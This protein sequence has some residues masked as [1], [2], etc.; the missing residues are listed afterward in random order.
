MGSKRI[1]LARLEAMVESLKRELAL[2][3]AILKGFRRS[4]KS[5]TNAA[6]LTLT[7]ADSGACVVMSGTAHKVTLP[8]PTAG[9]EYTIT[10]G[11]TAQYSIWT[12]GTNVMQ[13][14]MIHSSGTNTVAIV[15]V[16]A[17]GKIVSNSASVVGDTYHLRSDG[18]SWFVEACVDAVP[19]TG[20]F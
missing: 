17:Q 14:H 6:A 19:T 10:A 2:G 18:T 1:G 7:A 3:G 11:G 12:A 15:S 20:T 9:V 5:S 8:A 16:V 4:V 13:G